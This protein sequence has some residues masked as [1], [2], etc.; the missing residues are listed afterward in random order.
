VRNS[1]TRQGSTPTSYL[2]PRK[3]T[4]ER[5][6]PTA[7]IPEYKVASVRVEVL[8][9]D[10]DEDVLARPDV[11]RRSEPREKAAEDGT[12]DFRLFSLVDSLRESHP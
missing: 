10:T 1:S 5:F 3:L 11:G 7:G 9:P 2:R 12:Y 6:D 8:G 4:Q